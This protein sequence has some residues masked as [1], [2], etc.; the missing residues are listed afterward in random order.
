MICVKSFRGSA[1]PHET[2]RMEFSKWLA[3]KERS[4]SRKEGP[5][6]DQR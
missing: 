4:I 5:L 1:V 6:C 2:N 3:L